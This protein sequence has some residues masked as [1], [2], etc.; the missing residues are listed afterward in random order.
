M[1]L[2]QLL[3]NEN[4]ALWHQKK[5]HILCRLLHTWLFCVALHNH[6]L[7]MCCMAK[8]V[9]YDWNLHHQEFSFSTHSSWWWNHFS[10]M[11]K[12]EHTTQYTKLSTCYLHIFWL[13][14][15]SSILCILSDDKKVYHKR[16]TAIYQFH[17]FADALAIF[18]FSS[19]FSRF[20]QSFWCCG[21]NTGW[22]LQKPGSSPSPASMSHNIRHVF[23]FSTLLFP[24]LGD[25]T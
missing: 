6:D 25:W 10:P 1:L 11:R 18:D 7:F 22:K 3:S 13:F 19:F 20:L 9:G 8:L 24:N 5:M 4:E 15:F 16:K 14:V 12:D 23:N 2:Q 17:H 21:K